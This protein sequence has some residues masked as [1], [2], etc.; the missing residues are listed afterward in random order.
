MSANR[1]AVVCLDGR[2]VGVIEET[3]DGYST[4]FRYD[5]DYAASADAVPV[6]LTIPLALGEVTTAGLH[7][8]FK[9]LL[10]EGWLLDLAIRKLRIDESDDFGLLIA[11]GAD[12]AGAVEVHPDEEGGQ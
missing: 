2:R 3:K 7:P 1:R 8:F 4:T 9:N 5:P 11:T 10:P 6:S 12:C